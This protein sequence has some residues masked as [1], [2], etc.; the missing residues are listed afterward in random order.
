M[1]KFFIVFPLLVGISMFFLAS[2]SKGVPQTEYD[3][4][5][6]E[7]NTLQSEYDSTIKEY[8]KLSSKNQELNDA[9]SSL[10]SEYDSYKERM[11]PYENLEASEA[12]A[13]QIEADQVIAEQKAAEEAAAAEAAAL[14]AE[15][16]AKGYETGITYDDIARNPD[17]YIGKKVKFTGKVI[18]LIE[19]TSSIQIRF[20]INKDYDQVVLCEYDSS[21]VESR[22]LEDDIITI[23]G[24]SAGTIS[25]QSTLG[26]QITV[27]AIAVDRID[28]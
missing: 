17:E 18:Q 6:K 20:A 1:K 10:Q 24:L 25:Y 13:R 11:Q 12:E 16:E 15:E 28:Q 5:Q 23:Y 9:I 27:P 8:Q 21:I 22:V 2:C 4:L 7:L 26:G 19:G 14:L 3:D